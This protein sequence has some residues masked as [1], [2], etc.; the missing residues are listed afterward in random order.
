MP[1]CRMLLLMLSSVGS[2]PSRMPMP[3]SKNCR[4]P[5]AGQ[6]WP[7]PA[8]VWLPGVDEY[9]TGPGCGD[10]HLLQAAGEWGVQVR[11]WGVIILQKWVRVTFDSEER[12]QGYRER[13]IGRESPEW[14]S[15]GF[16]PHSLS[17]CIY[18]CVY[19]DNQTYLTLW[20]TLDINIALHI[21]VGRQRIR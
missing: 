13:T 9:Q 7:G 10:R 21:S 18:M 15:W 2:W 12:E 1:T 4:P 20:F 3:S 6:G 11:G 5:S 19:I 17:L 16:R 14:Q 8:G